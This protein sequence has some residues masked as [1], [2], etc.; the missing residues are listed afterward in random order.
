MKKLI[1]LCAVGLTVLLLG[2]LLFSTGCTWRDS[3]VSA[4]TCVHR[5]DVTS[6]NSGGAIAIYQVRNAG[7]SRE[8]YAQRVSSE[9]DLLCGEKGMLIDSGYGGGCGG[10]LRIVNDGSGG[11]ITAW[12]AYP[13]NPD[14][15]SPTGE[16]VQKVVTVI[17]VDSQGRILWQKEVKSFDIV[18]HMISD[19]AGGVI[20]ACDDYSSRYLHIQKV[21]TE[22]DFPWD[23]DGVSIYCEEYQNNSLELASDGSGGAIVTYCESIA[24]TEGRIFAHRVDSDGNLSWGQDGVLLYTTPKEIAGQ[25]IR[26]TSDGSG[27]V[28]VVWQQSDWGWPKL[29]DICVQR[30][31]ADGDILWQSEGTPVFIRSQMGHAAD[32][33]L[34]SDGS[35]GAIVFWESGMSIYAQRLNSNGETLWAKWGIQVWQDGDI[36]RLT[37]KVESDAS[38]GALIVWYYIGST[39]AD[40]GEILRAQRLDA[41]GRAMWLSGGVPVAIGV[42]ENCNYATISQ[43]GLGGVLIAWG[44]GRDVYTVEKS[45]VQ[46]IDAEGNSLWGEKGIRLDH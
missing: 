43:D 34:V 7:D 1:V 46:R 12:K 13:T 29:Y 22:G 18:D 14:L 6:D 16:R 45:Y 21:D 17:R 26:V 25:E 9:G 3:G 27:G 30:V 39:L 2:S 41:D 24:E 44:T 10:L 32:P 35:G 36:A 5:P 40:K 28:I 20:I 8:L 33:T 11:A 4:T 15:E 37:Y 31:D 19:G 23:E 38:G 42:K